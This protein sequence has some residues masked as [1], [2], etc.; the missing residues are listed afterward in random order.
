MSWKFINT[1]YI[2]R[3]G[4]S[5]IYYSSL[6]KTFSVWVESKDKRGLSKLFESPYINT[7]KRFREAISSR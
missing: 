5:Q 7:C 3:V 1:K 4:N 2:D 6:D